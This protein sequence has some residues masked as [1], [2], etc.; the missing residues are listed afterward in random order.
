M[1]TRYAPFYTSKTEEKKSWVLLFT[2]VFCTIVQPTFSPIC[3]H[4]ASFFAPKCASRSKSTEK[5]FQRLPRPKPLRAV[6]EVA[7]SPNRS[8]GPPITKPGPATDCWT[9][10]FVINVFEIKTPSSKFS[11]LVCYYSHFKSSQSL[12]LLL[13]HSL[14]QLLIL[15]LSCFTRWGFEAIVHMHELINC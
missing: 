10:Y 12:P 13:S 11:R 3:V 6:V 8:H 4:F 5:M 7:P 14:S 1:Y 2:T 9:V 15:L